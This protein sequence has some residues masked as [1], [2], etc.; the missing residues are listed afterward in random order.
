MPTWP[1]SSVPHS[2]PTGNAE[3]DLRSLTGIRSSKRSFYIEYR[4]TSLRLER[5]VRSLERVAHVLGSTSQGPASLCTE[6]VEAAG[7]HLGARRMVLVLADGALPE[8]SFRAV[9]WRRHQGVTL[10]EAGLGRAERQLIDLTLNTL[11]HAGEVC[12][13]FLQGDLC[14]VP[15]PVEGSMVGLLVG[16]VD[17][18]GPLSDADLSVLHILGSQVAVALR[19]DD[20]LRRSERLRAEAE[21]Q[22][23]DLAERNLEVRETR[24]RLSIAEQQATIETERRRIAR[25]LHDSV[26]QHM[27]SAGMTIEWCRAEVDPDSEVHER[28]SRATTLTRTAIGQ[29]RSAIGALTQ[30][31]D[32][33]ED[34]PG[35]LQQLA[36]VHA[37]SK[38]DVALRVEG[39]PLPLP[40]SMDHALLRIAGEAVFNATRHGEASRIIVR[41]SYRPEVVRL[42]VADDGCGDP[43]DLRRHV[44]AAAAPGRGAGYQQ[45]LAN[46]ISRAEELGGLLRF[47]RARLGGIRVVAQLPLTADGGPA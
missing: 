38:I 26:A 5:A 8:A 28:L 13:P 24:T 30:Q 44:A 32:T 46:M 41:L 43:E 18:P 29:L 33:D 20:L 37:S 3:D 36:R 39:R 7:A 4:A 9:C 2:E 45:G 16:W 47:R 34:L 11:R 27:L 42:S 35:M 22:A 1:R 14:V 21:R 40:K 25:E 31:V 12:E 10:G 17:D 23:A 19:N 6:V 15:L